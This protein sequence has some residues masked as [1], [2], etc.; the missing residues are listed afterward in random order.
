MKAL[1]W[2]LLFVTLC[3]LGWVIH[4]RPQDDSSRVID[5]LASV[6]SRESALIDDL[7]SDRRRAWGKFDSLREAYKQNID[8]LTSGA[9]NARRHPRVVEINR[10]V[11]EVR[12]A[13]VSDDNVINALRGRITYLDSATDSHRIAD[14]TYT[15][16]RDGLDDAFRS[17]ISALN[18]YIGRHDK[19]V[20]LGISAGP[21]LV[22]TPG[23]KVY[24]GLGVTVG[25][26]LKL[27][28]KRR[29]RN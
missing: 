10:T 16:V 1:P 26:A 29:H 9:Q 4:F 15:L 2:I 6:I 3:A 7:D 25:V 19:P 17:E 5:S 22:V 14:S 13:F 28:I 18:D 8:S 27:P 21:G 20:S 24:G 23:G 11:P 12:T